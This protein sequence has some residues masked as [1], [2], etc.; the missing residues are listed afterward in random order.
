MGTATGSATKLVM[1]ATSYFTDLWMLVRSAPGWRHSGTVPC[2]LLRACRHARHVGRSAKCCASRCRMPP[3]PVQDE[4]ARWVKVWHYT[5]YGMVTM[6][7]RGPRGRRAC[8]PRARRARASSGH[9]APLR[10]PHAAGSLHAPAAAVQ[11]RQIMPE[12]RELLDAEEW[13]V[14]EAAPTRRQVPWLKMQQ[15][16]AAADLPDGQALLMDTWLQRCDAEADACARFRSTALP[17]NLTL[18]STGFIQIWIM[19]LPIG[20]IQ[21]GDW[22]TLFPYFWLALLLLACDELATQL[23]VRRQRRRRRRAAPRACLPGRAGAVPCLLPVCTA[24]RAA[25][26]PAPMASHCRCRPQDPFTFLPCLDILTVQVRD[27]Q[28]CVLA[29]APPLTCAPCCAAVGSIGCIMLTHCC[30]CRSA[31]LQGYRGRHCAAEDCRPPKGSHGLRQRQAGGSRRDR[32]AAAAKGGRHRSRPA[33]SHAIP[34]GS[35][36]CARAAYGC[37]SRGPPV[38]PMSPCCL[39]AWGILRTGHADGGVHG[40]IVRSVGHRRNPLP[41]A[42]HARRFFWRML[43]SL[44]LMAVAQDVLVQWCESHVRGVPFRRPQATNCG[45]PQGRWQGQR[46]GRRRRP[47]MALQARG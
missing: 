6:Q 13:A 41:A 30:S 20:Y 24:L 16:L 22:W 32:V 17:Y 8:T 5:I 33:V 10:G 38:N 2:C 11:P 35:H 23:E 37:L 45:R 14:Y 43:L 1:Q 15:L 3:L 42:L 21:E 34:C 46:Q 4:L 26:Q 31:L 28:K 18:L 36:S 39:V 47:H 9:P 25:A 40:G 44:M 7:V 12:T 19:L 27:V 29:A